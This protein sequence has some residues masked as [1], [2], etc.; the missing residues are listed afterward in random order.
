MEYYYDN[1]DW[2]K[3]QF[4][5]RQVERYYSPPSSRRR[6]SLVSSDPDDVS[7]SAASVVSEDLGDGDLQLQLQD[8]SRATRQNNGQPSR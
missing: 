5:S 6:P 4:V 7:D 3:E 2:K 8:R 1:F